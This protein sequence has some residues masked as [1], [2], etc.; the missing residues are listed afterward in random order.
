MTNPHLRR[1]RLIGAAVLGV[2]QSGTVPTATTAPR[3]VT[4]GLA[5]GS[6]RTRAGR[7]VAADAGDRE[8]ASARG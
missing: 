8:A 2:G 5:P 6:W 3:S 4:V 1:H 7:K